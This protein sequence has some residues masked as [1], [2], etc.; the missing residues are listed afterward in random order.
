MYTFWGKF[1]AKAQS[2]HLLPYHCLDVAAVLKVLLSQDS[3]REQWRIVTKNDEELFDLSL[4]VFLAALH[5]VGKFSDTFQSKAPD[6]CSLLSR[7]SKNIAGSHHTDEGLWLVSRKLL[8][9]LA[10]LFDDDPDDLFDALEPYLKAT[11]CHHGAPSISMPHHVYG[12]SSS[13]P[14]AVEFTREIFS[15]LLEEPQLPAEDAQ[16][17]AS[18]LFAGLMVIADWVG[19]NDVWFPHSSDPIPLQMYWETKALPQ[20]EYAVE[21]A[22]L[23]LPKASVASTFTSLM[24]HLGN[25]AVPSPL[26]TY[27]MKEAVR[28]NTPQLH[29]F[30][31]VTG[32]GK[33]EAALLCAHQIMR[34]TAASGFY[35]ALPTMAT[36]NGMYSRLS[37]TYQ[38]LFEGSNTPSLVLAHGGRHIH[39]G[40]LHTI[41]RRDM[42]G[43]DCNAY[44]TTWLADSRKKALLSQCGVGTIDQ[45]LLG[46]LPSRH[47]ALRLAGMSQ[48]VLIFDEIHAYDGYTAELVKRLLQFHAALGGSAILL[49]ATLPL[50]MKQSF[51]DAFAKGAGYRGELAESGAFPLATSLDSEGSQAV[52]FEA[53][54]TLDVKITLT[55]SEKDVFEKI[56]SVVHAG[57]CVCWVRNTVAQAVEAYLL[58]HEKYGIAPE[59]ALLFHS[60]FAM[61]DRLAIEN[62]VL[63]TFG[64]KSTPEDRKGKVLVA[65]QVVEQSLDVDFD[66]LVTDLAPIELL[67]QR[68]GRCQRHIRPRPAV[69][70][71]PEVMVLS[72]QPTENTSGSWYKALLGNAA[73]VYPFQS[74]L[75]KTAALLHDKQ[76]IVLPQQAR[77][78]VETVYDPDTSCPDVLIEL[79]AKNAQAEEFAKHS[80]A[81]SN[82]LKF[83]EGYSFESSEKGWGCDENYPTRI[84]TPTERIRLLKHE[85][86]TLSLWSDEENMSKACVLS[87]LS[88]RLDAITP[89]V[90]DSLQKQYKAVCES[91][92]DKGEWVKVLILEERDG[93]WVGVA[94]E[95]IKYSI[96]IGLCL[97]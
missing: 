26:Q 53:T 68:A 64:K 72:P 80:I 85:S 63:A 8:Q 46:V 51:I 89:V 12:F 28:T 50:R 47:Q 67:I 32:G 19:S 3:I 2:L 31:D 54:R 83:D 11:C 60:R 25:S 30:E 29:I 61:E 27:A 97:D 44:C 57:G 82:L 88:Y 75:W 42:S 79:D 58:L 86:G 4:F 24:P 10:E 13:V 1:D 20:A 48:H 56:S 81:I 16:E 59:S 62:N 52:A 34:Q 55:D 22:G 90:P 87:E 94:K 66:Y 74:V 37:Q 15:F 35:V 95:K 65:T 9:I 76:R 40:F 69:A 43:E 70:Q 45:A 77:M 7:E 18:W 23:V 36:A 6:A 73:Y 91:M 96:A 41:G 14:S 5:D 21:Q 84:G 92:P 49:S 38:V 17:A 93:Q 39:D 33:T 71:E 78:F